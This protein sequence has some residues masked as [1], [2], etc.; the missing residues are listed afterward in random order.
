M[1]IIDMLA[2][3]INIIELTMNGGV[4]LASAISSANASKLMALVQT[5]LSSGAQVNMDAVD[6]RAAAVY[7]SHSG[8]TAETLEL[9]DAR[10]AEK[11]A[12]CNFELLQGVAQQ[13]WQN[14]VVVKPSKE[15]SIRCARPF[16][17]S[18]VQSAVR[19]TSICP[20]F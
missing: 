13:S 19:S 7:Q 3:G 14:V 15:L 8:S 5:S 9:A 18:A 4:L 11:T 12:H 20:F 2:R 6:A 17:K 1:E 16:P 10:Q